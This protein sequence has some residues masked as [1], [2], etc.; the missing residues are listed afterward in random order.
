MNC[1][2]PHATDTCQSKYT[3]RHCGQ[4]HNS[5]LHTETSF[6][7]ATESET[8]EELDP[9][10]Q[11]AIEME[12]LICTH[13]QPTDKPAT[14]ML[15]TAL[16]RINY[17]EKSMLFRALLD[18]GSTA[19]LISKRA[20]EALGLPQCDVNIPITGVGGNETFR[21]KRR[22]Q[23]QISPF[24]TNSV[25]VGIGAYIMPS[26]TT[27]PISPDCNKWSHLKNLHLADP[28]MGRNGRIDVLLGNGTLSEI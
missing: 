19:D 14:S 26:I 6:H 7:L 15:P 27:L 10:E 4:K 24:F 22:T 25:S 18:Q 12:Q 8:E 28:K 11:Q 17:D 21:V 5:I 13:V 16:I 2:F 23:F 1:L 20:C 3:C 9:D